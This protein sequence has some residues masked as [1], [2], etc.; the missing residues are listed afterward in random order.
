MTKHFDKSAKLK[1]FKA[2]ILP[3]FVYGDFIYSNALISSVDKLR[4]A[5][6]AC[7]RYVFNLTRYSR[8]SHLHK[9]L[10]GCSFSNFYKYISCV[11]IFKIM[12]MRKPDYLF[13]KLHP[14]RSDRN[15]NFLIPQH[16][17]TYYSQ[18]LF[19]RG[20]VNW[21]QLRLTIKSNLSMSTFKRDLIQH[22]TA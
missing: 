22:M 13:E 21:N 3:H 11:T 18:S 8:V 16:Q 10:I 6:N 14:L 15:R 1:L 5:F 20:V 19:T 2:L 17:T 4:I 12:K 7:V 9:E